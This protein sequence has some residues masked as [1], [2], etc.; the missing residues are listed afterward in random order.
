VDDNA[1]LTC[2]QVTDAERLLC[3]TLASVCRNILCPILVSLKKKERKPWLV[4]L[5]SF[6]FPYFLVPL[7][8][9]HPFRGS[10]DV[11]AFRAEVN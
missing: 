9:Q 8:L 10:T 7:F 5:A 2:S 11:H 6:K 4:P 3:E 1:A